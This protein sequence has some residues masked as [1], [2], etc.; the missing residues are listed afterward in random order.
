MA[1]QHND[2]LEELFFTYIFGHKVVFTCLS[3]F[4]NLTRILT[5]CVTARLTA[6]LRL[7]WARLEFGSAVHGSNRGGG[8]VLGTAAATLRAPCTSQ[9][10][11]GAGYGSTRTADTH[12]VWDFHGLL[13]AALA[14]L[15]YGSAVAEWGWEG[16][17]FYRGD[18]WRLW[19]LLGA[20]SRHVGAKHQ[21]LLFLVE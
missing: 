13:E 14:M 10:T 12:F 7:R 21:R 17:I 9:D 2:I 4:E 8:A 18:I 11:S 15:L 20:A 1:S 3:Y 19:R 16:V 5:A 6:S